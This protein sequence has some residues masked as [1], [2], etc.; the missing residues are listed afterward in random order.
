MRQI[1]GTVLT[2][3]YSDL[4]LSGKT[5]QVIHGILHSA[6]RQAQRDGL[7]ADNPADFCELPKVEDKQVAVPSH[8]D[9]ARVLKVNS[10]RWEATA[11]LMMVA[12]GLSRGEA[13][14]LCWRD[15]DLD[16]GT[17]KVERNVQAFN[18][19]IV[20]LPPKSKAGRRQV[21]IPAA[22]VAHLKEYRQRQR[23]DFMRRGFR[24]EDDILFPSR[25][26][27]LR[28]PSTFGAAIKA[29]GERAGASL[30]PHMLRHRF[31]TDMLMGN[32][33]PRIA[34][35]RL[36]HARIATT[37][38]VYQHVIE[39]AQKEAADLAGEV[40]GKLIE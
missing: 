3:F 35:A 13:V 34:Q 18:G 17:L 10:G 1:T 16:A 12:A 4:P 11:I 23:E 8:D 2:V 37:Q 15:I 27:G 21:A 29:A 9:I 33:N 31:G 30:S 19:N 20:V 6:L 38:Q 26:G 32:I 25:H 22:L 24:P 36:G 39:D 40:V 7:I 5:V 14:G 28:K